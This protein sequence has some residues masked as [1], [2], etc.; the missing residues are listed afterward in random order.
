VD[1]TYVELDICLQEK[2]FRSQFYILHKRD[3]YVVLRKRLVRKKK[4]FCKI[5]YSSIGITE[6]MYLWK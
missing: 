1:T 5:E 3:D 2:Y 6:I 4:E